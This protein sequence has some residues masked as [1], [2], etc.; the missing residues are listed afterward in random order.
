MPDDTKPFFLTFTDPETWDEATWSGTV[1]LVDPENPLK[2]VP[3]L[4]IGFAGFEDGKKIFQRWIDGLG[5]ADKYEELRVSIVEGPI[6]GQPDGY[7]V[8]ISINPENTIRRMAEAHISLPTGS[9]MLMARFNRMNS[10]NSPNLANFKKAFAHFGFY[11][12]FPAHVSNARII[13]MELSLY[14][15]KKE[16]HF[17]QS[18][19]IKAG[20]PES[21]VLVP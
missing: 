3:G 16:L 19:N 15:E 4:G 18:S 12:I 17:I 11:R 14:I 13:D 10:R 5:S 1:F 6:K 7:S 2:M 20:D 8:F 9:G 21:V